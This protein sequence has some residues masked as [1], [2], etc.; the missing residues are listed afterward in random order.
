[1][2][3]PKLETATYKTELPITKKKI[4]YRPFLV[5]EQ[6]VLLIALES[7]EEDQANNSMLDLVGNCVLNRDSVGNLE[8]LPMMD[9]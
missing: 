5:K 4:E 7:E 8:E 1:M 2:T 3:L 9:L 6:K